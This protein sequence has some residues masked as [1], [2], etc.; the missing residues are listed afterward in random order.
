MPP[1]SQNRSFF[2]DLRL[3][4]SE[5]FPDFLGFYKYAKSMVVVLLLRAYK[6][7]DVLKIHE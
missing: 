5:H 1:E 3:L 6:F 4:M 7:L 2:T